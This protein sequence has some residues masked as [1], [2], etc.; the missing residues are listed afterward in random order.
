MQFS[1]C[2]TVKPVISRYFGVLLFQIQALRAG[3]S[4]FHTVEPAS[5]TTDKLIFLKTIKLRTAHDGE[6]DVL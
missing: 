5:V 6:N 2:I 3:V 4:S 1:V